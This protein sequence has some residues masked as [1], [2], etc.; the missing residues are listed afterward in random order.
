MKTS[1]VF[2]SAL[3][4][5]VVVTTMTSAQSGNVTQSWERTYGGSEGD[6]ASAIRMPPDGGYIVAGTTE[7]KGVGKN[8]VWV[9]KLDGQGRLE[10]ER[11]YGGSEDEYASDIQTTPDGGYVV[12]GGT[13][14]KG[15][16]YN[17]AWVIKLDAKGQQI[18]DQ[19]INGY[20]PSIDYSV[21]MLYALRTA[22]DDGY[23]AAGV[24]ISKDS[25]ASGGRVIKLDTQGH[26]IWDHTFGGLD[27]DSLHALQVTP[28]G[29]CIVAGNTRSYKKSSGYRDAWVIKL[30]AQGRKVW[31][32]TFNRGE[33]G[34]SAYA[35]QTTPDGGYIVAGYTES[36]GAGKSDVWLIKLDAQG[37]KVWDRTFGGS[38]NDRATAIQT[39][40]DG[41]YIV[42][43]Y[44]KS[45]GAGKSDAW[46]IKLNSEGLLSE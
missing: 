19:T 4:A 21:Y 5:L 43:G 15:A 39:T 22:P 26:K 40:S 6:V 9:F 32:R 2:V 16:G 11:T 7:S 29:G 17:N 42:A 44:T 20:D 14:S 8:D 12:A 38:G 37:R 46:V 10:W 13:T 28:D 35:L 25:G 30:N 3:F 33:P 36:K 34:D 41:G 24:S 23:V 27:Y 18:W 45:K 1:I 31:D